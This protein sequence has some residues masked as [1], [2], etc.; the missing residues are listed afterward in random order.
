M[1]KEFEWKRISDILL[2][3]YDQESTLNI[4]AAFLKSIQ[5][6]ISHN[7]SNFRVFNP[8][9]G[10]EF[11]DDAVFMGVDGDKIQLFYE[12]IANEKDYLSNYYNCDSSLVY[13]DTDVLPKK[14]REKTDFYKY[15]LLPQKMPYVCGIIIIKDTNLIGIMNLFRSEEWGDFTEKECYILEIFKPHI[16]NLIVKSIGNKDNSLFN[17]AIIDEH[18]NKLPITAREREITKLILKGNSNADI[19]K[20]LNVSLSTVKKHI[21]NIFLKLNINSKL[22][23]IKMFNKK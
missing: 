10:H 22:D 13:C 9:S 12:N 8:V 16:T 5:S 21:Y 6:L 23:L 17:K 2:Q 15:Y 14:V 4:A 19:A 20:K 1:L 3:V 7:Q 18:L 11:L